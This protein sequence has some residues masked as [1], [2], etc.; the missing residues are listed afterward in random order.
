MAKSDGSDYLFRSQKG[1]RLSRVQFFRV[2]RPVLI[3]PESQRR[4]VI[5]TR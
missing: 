2:F 5:R 4:N 1:G 3:K